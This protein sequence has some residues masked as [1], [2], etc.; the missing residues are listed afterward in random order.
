MG[1]ILLVMALPALQVGAAIV[2]AFLVLVLPDYDEK[3]AY[4]ASLGRIAAGT[5]IGTVAGMG[6][7]LG[8]GGALSMLP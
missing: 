3:G 1:L 8:A 4:L 6:V 5:I 7:M 2:A